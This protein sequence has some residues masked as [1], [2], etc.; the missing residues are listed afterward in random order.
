MLLIFTL[1]VFGNLLVMSAVMRR[2]Q[3]R[4][5]RN[6]FIFN[7]SLSDF[8]LATSIPFTVMDA[9]TRAWPLPH[10]WLACKYLLNCRCLLNDLPLSSSKAGKDF[11]LHSGLHV[12]ADNCCRRCW[13]VQ[14]HRPLSKS[15]GALALNWYTSK[16]FKNALSQQ[17]LKLPTVLGNEI[18]GNFFQRIFKNSDRIQ[19]LPNHY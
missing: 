18:R 1:K 13:Q 3:M 15:T 19:V 9:L 7:L 8:L 6:I 17:L 12:F 11:P 2:K 4:T 14:N 10:S 16:V 5:A